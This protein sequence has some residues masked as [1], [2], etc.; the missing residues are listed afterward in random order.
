MWFLELGHQ[1]VSLGKIWAICQMGRW[2]VFLDP[3]SQPFLIRSQFSLWLNCY[4]MLWLYIDKSRLQV[5]PQSIYGSY[6][7]NSLSW[8]F[9]YFR[10]EYG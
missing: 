7:K 2:P 3:N 9:I 10:I 5:I 6:P 8:E 1:R 4:E